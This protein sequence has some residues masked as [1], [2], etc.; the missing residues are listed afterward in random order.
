MKTLPLILLIIGIIQAEVG[1]YSQRYSDQALDQRLCVSLVVGH[2]YLEN[3]LSAIMDKYMK[4]YNEPE[5]YNFKR[6]KYKKND[7]AEKDMNVKF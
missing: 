6:D 2:Q 5:K 7:K 4:F 3:S 1:E